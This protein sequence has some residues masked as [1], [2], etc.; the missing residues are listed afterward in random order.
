MVGVL[1]T[2]KGLQFASLPRTNVE[3]RGPFQ[4]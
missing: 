2:G 3:K 4:L 1:A